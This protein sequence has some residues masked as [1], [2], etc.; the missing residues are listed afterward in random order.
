MKNRLSRVKL[1]SRLQIATSVRSKLA[2]LFL[3]VAILPLA[4]L[5][6][7]SYNKSSQI[8][9]TQFGS[10]GLYAV[11][12]LKLHLDTS[13]KQM[14]NI[15]GNILSYLISSPIV[16]EDQEPSTYSEYSEEKS[17]TRYLSSLEN[18]NILSV[19]I[20][21]PSGKMIGNNA[22]NPK[23]LM[24]SDFWSRLPDTKA[25]QIIMHKP[26]Y[27]TSTTADTV[28]SLI[29]PVK[30]HFG[31]PPG[32]KILIDMR[33]DAILKLVRDFEFD[34][35]SHL[36]IRDQEGRILLQ[37]ANAYEFKDNDIVWSKHLDME[38]WVVEARIPFRTF[39]E[40]SG[41]ILQYSLLIAI[42][43]LLLAIVMG[44][45]F[46]F[47]FT[48]PIKKLTQSIRRF[49][50]GDLSIQTPIYTSDEL[51]FLS[52]AFNR[53]T[54]QI[55]ELIGEISRTE[56]LKSEAELRALHYQINPHLLFNTL[57]SIQWKARL[58]HQSDIQQM[59]QHLVAIL[60]RSFD[61]SQVLVP[62][63][64]ELEVVRHYLEIQYY[65]FE[66]AFTYTLHVEPGLEHCLIPRMVFQ[67]LLENIFFHGFIDGTGHI[68]LNISTSNNLI[69][70]ELTD[71]G[72]GIKQELMK[73]IASG[74]KIHDKKGGL[75][76]RN[77]DERFK[78]HFGQQYGLSVHSE[79]NQGTKVSM[80]WPKTT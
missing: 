56:K 55:K 4:T 17:F 6:Y 50:Q 67:P 28:I 8:V 15:T 24:E 59:L 76:M 70:V 32:S 41:V 25:K 73:Y 29:V 39:Y 42:L 16:I 52:E 10:Y 1:A 44:G 11:E 72:V 18:P 58:A 19:N 13:L 53:M 14:D 37:T 74:Q 54:G 36:Q 71:D 30:N 26:D 23:L 35:K 12:Q 38:N 66:D 60:E 48:R 65:R 57:N 69:K 46:S 20:V 68:E 62:L 2:V 9:N 22:I 5:C 7:F 49:G 80:I 3:I 33:G 63:H 61:V 64:K 77:V 27:Y 31:L 51:G 45:F 40:A 34:T 47:R 78:L 43:A 21:T 79:R 75:G